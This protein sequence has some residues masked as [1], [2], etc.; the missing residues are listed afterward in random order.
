MKSL[1]FDAE[2]RWGVK[3]FAGDSFDACWQMLAI[4]LPVVGPSMM[5]NLVNF[6][7]SKMVLYIDQF[8]H[9]VL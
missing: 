8:W 1:N 4:N 6:S 7:D 9:C 2:T 5:M 3:D